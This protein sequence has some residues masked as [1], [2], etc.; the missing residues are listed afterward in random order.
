VAGGVPE[1]DQA[2]VGGIDVLVAGLEVLLLPEVLDHRAEHGAPLTPDG[3][4]GP[5]L[6]AEEEEAEVGA[7]AP[8]VALAGLLEAPEVGLQLRLG[9]P[10]RAVDPLELGAA[11][12]APPVGAGEAEELEGADLPR[13]GDVGATAEVLEVALAVEG[14]P[15]PLDATGVWA[16]RR[17]VAGAEVLAGG[18]ALD[19]LHLVGLVA[20]PEEGERLVAIELAA[21]EGEVGRDDVLHPAL[22]LGQVVEGQATGEVEVVVEPV[23]DRR[24][25]AE[26]GLG[27]HLLDG[28]GHDVGR[29]VAHRAQVDAGGL[30][31]R[32]GPRCG[33]GFALDRLCHRLVSSSPRG[34]RAGCAAG[35]RAAGHEA[36]QKRPVSH[37]LG[38]EAHKRR[39]DRAVPPKF[40]PR[41]TN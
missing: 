5:D 38:R 32:W 41:R 8:V 33:S 2:D 20:L 17:L 40:G 14:D 24:A 36:N 6:L 31:P 1:V 18:E 37:T 21:L 16:V 28:L 30:A 9:R 11:I 29:G 35:C 12:V 27:E 15:P 19:Q 7:E 4:P 25:D 10:G 3:E 22:D 26:L 23:L 39:R 13:P 34:L